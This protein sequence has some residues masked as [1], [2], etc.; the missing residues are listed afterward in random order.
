VSILLISET[1]G[2]EKTILLCHDRYMFRSS[3]PRQESNRSRLCTSA[4]NS[5]YGRGESGCNDGK[6]AK[7]TIIDKEVGFCPEMIVAGL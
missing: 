7:V 2:T 6:E 5:D 1:G 3:N 4:T